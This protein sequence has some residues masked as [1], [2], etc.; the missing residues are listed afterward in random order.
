MLCPRGGG[1]V[2]W[3]SFKR[4]HERLWRSSKWGQVN[5]TGTFL[6]GILVGGVLVS[7][8]AFRMGQA[9]QQAQER[10]GREPTSISH[11]AEKAND[12]VVRRYTKHDEM[13]LDGDAAK[14][15][16]YTAVL[17]CD[18]AITSNFLC[19]LPQISCDERS[20]ARVGRLKLC[21]PKES[22]PLVAPLRSGTPRR[23]SCRVHDVVNESVFCILTE[24]G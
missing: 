17:R 5:R 16:I 12:L 2:L 7:Q 14:G 1:G 11:P 8:V 24:D 10:I 21:F 4:L 13:L 9:D 22:A 15:G 18:T 20:N 6:L 19:P 3:S 23:I